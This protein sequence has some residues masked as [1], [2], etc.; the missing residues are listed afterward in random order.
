LFLIGEVF[1]APPY[2]AKFLAGGIGSSCLITG[3]MGLRNSLSS[4]NVIVAL[5]FVSILLMIAR[6]SNSLEKW[7]SYL[8]KAPKLTVSII[9]L[10]NLSIV[11]KLE[12]GE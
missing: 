1:L 5:P 8:K 3:T 9:P 12:S 7:P 11:L 6:S 10:L 4:S 2:P